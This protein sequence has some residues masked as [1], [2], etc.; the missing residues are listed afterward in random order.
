MEDSSDSVIGHVAIHPE[1]GNPF[2][3]DDD[4]CVLMGSSE[5][6]G[7]FIKASTGEEVDAS[8]F[9]ALTYDEVLNDLAYGGAIAFDADAYQRFA[10]QAAA[11]DMSTPG[12]E[13]IAMEVEGIDVVLGIL[14]MDAD[15]ED[16]DA[17]GSEA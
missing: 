8:A 6:L 16:D 3:C 9:R 14:E 5:A 15:Q 2:C 11:D 17:A 7:N 10:A 12:F 13:D 4:A 1:T